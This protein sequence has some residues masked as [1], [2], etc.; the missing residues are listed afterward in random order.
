MET[1]CIDVCT[2][3]PVTGLCEGCAR[4]IDEITQWASYTPA[5]RRRIMAELESRKAALVAR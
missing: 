4:S 3:D 2:L 5:E 1:P